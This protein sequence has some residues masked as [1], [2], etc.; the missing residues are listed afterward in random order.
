MEIFFSPN[1]NMT[2]KAQSDNQVKR[3]VLIS[4]SILFLLGCKEDKRYLVVSKVKSTCAL[5]TTETIIDKVV[6]GYKEKRTF[7]RLFA[8][9]EASF[10]AETEATIKTGVRL[11]K[12]MPEDVIIKGDRI[13]LKLP[14]VEVLNFDYPFEAVRVNEVASR[15]ALF[16]QVTVEDEEMFL[17]MA[18]SDIR[19]HLEYTGIVKQTQ[20]NV[21]SMLMGILTQLGYEEIYIVFKSDDLI[22]QIV[23]PQE[24]LSKDDD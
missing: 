7:F 5:A 8:L 10:L 1:Q 2:K 15:N 14:A 9:G 23:I 6:I 20:D 18:E 17:R 11:E 21:R 12:I 24:L 4:I 13:E 22:Q 16:N 19:K 3:F